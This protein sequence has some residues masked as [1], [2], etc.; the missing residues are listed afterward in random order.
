MV[1]NDVCT[2][3]IPTKNRREKGRG[4]RGEGEGEREMR[5]EKKGR[6]FVVVIHQK[7]DMGED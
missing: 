6:A 5:E 7:G 1:G 2:K 3:G 4:R